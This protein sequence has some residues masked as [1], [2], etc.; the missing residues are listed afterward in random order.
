MDKLIQTETRG[1]GQ[2]PLV[3]SL[4]AG[5]FFML[6]MYLLSFVMFFP[7]KYSF[8]NTIRVP[9]GLGPDQVQ[10]VCKCYQQ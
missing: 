5:Y 1:C 8:R 10:T 9:N 4:H 2:V 6:L 7:S 3:N